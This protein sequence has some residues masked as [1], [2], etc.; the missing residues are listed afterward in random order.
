M[1]DGAASE[2]AQFRFTRFSLRIGARACGWAGVQAFL[3]ARRAHLISNGEHALYY[4]HLISDG[5]HMLY[6]AHL[7]SNGE[8]MLYYAH[9]ISDGEHMLY[10]AHLIQD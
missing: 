5:E 10:Y 8:H 9:L 6:F 2:R 4:A 7:I 3:R 1:G